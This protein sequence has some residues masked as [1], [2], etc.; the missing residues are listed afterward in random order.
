MADSNY[1]AVL[2]PNLTPNQTTTMRKRIWIPLVIVLAVCLLLLFR[3]K[4]PQTSVTPQSSRALTNQPSQTAPPKNVSRPPVT[5][6]AQIEAVF[7]PKT[8]LAQALAKTNPLAAIRLAM[9]QAPIEF[10]G[11]VIDENSNAVAGANI[12]FKWTEIPAPD[13]NREATTESDAEGLFSLQ[14][15]RGPSL[16][17]WVS[18][19]GYYAPHRGEW[20]FNYALGPDIISPDPH[21]P[22]IFKLHKKGKGESLIDKDFPSVFTQIWQL[23]HDG[24][25]I[26]LDLLNGNQNV[27]GSGQLKLEFWRDISNLNKHPF[28]WK[29]QLSV[30]GGGGLVPT[31][32]EFAFEAPQNGYQPSIVIDMPATNQV[33]LSEIR[34]KYY[35]QLPN[36]DYG[37]I[38]FYLL[39]YNG[40][41]TVHSAVN[42]TGSQNLEPAQ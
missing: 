3:T 37:R 15:K 42:P 28:D 25:P 39:P 26:E 30:L 4:Q 10:Y 7:P 16:E 21:N 13:G 35:I 11:K 8:P 6:I 27:N 18:K 24:T 40:V 9:W 36:G 20:G 31:D 14:N 41:F 2:Q 19:D 33:W 23:H 34:S 38:D 32:E 5:N 1:P 22:I 29:L 12:T 17:I